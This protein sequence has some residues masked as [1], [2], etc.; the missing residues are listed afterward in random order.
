MLFEECY[1]RVSF[2]TLCT[3]RQIPLL[4]VLLACA[5]KTCGITYFV[6]YNQNLLFTTHLT[7]PHCNR[8]NLLLA[9]RPIGYVLKGVIPNYSVLQVTTVAFGNLAPHLR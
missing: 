5:R 4:Q 8:Q 7:P 3:Q 1:I 6:C 2:A 9:P